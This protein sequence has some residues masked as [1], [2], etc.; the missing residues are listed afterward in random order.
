MEEFYDS[1]RWYHE[2]SREQREF[3]GVVVNELATG[4]EID[5][6]V[7]NALKRISTMKDFVAT[8]SMPELKEYYEQIRSMDLEITIA[9]NIRNVAALRKRRAQQDVRE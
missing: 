8:K 3:D 1:S 6:A 4:K 5:T 9:N 2:R 7:T